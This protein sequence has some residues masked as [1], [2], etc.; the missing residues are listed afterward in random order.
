MTLSDAV[1]VQKAG[2]E[3]VCSF[4]SKP[5]EAV[6]KLIEGPKAF[7]CDECVFL[8]YNIIKAEEGDSWSLDLTA[9]FQEDLASILLKNKA[10]G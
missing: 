10:K 7:I 3:L 2:R 9:I 8:S 4:C 5:R 1:G 6:K